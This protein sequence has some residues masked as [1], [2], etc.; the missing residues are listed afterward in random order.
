MTP[1]PLSKGESLP[2]FSEN[3]LDQYFEGQNQTIM[4]PANSSVVFE[5]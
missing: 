2:L 4:S 3:L 1:F 5:G